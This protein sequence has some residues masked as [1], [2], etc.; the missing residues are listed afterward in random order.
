MSDSVRVVI[1]D[2]Q[3]LFRQGLHQI[4]VA[5]AGV[6]VVGESATGP[7]TINMVRHHK[8]DVT[9]LDL[10][11]PPSD[12]AAIIPTLRKE[13]PGTRPLVLTA[14]QDESMVV[15]ALRAGA[16]GYISKNASV[17]ELTKAI[18][19]VHQGEMWIERRMMTRYLNLESQFDSAFAWDKDKTNNELSPREHEVLSCVAKGW[20]NKEIAQVL[21]ISEKTVK[22]HLSNI[23]R[24]MNVTRRLQAILHAVEQ[25]F[26]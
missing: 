10:F 15:K 12:A 5:G 21:C 11:L 9:L 6:N 1:A 4:L 8:P 19:S 7:E 2:S 24:K 23:F 26:L 17:S 16:R 18:H 14:T 3:G 13:S 25:G 22:S 20:T